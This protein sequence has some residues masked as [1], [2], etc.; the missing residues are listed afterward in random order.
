[1]HRAG[2]V[3]QQQTALAQLVNELVERGLADPVDAVIA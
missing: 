3:R 2:V 1:M